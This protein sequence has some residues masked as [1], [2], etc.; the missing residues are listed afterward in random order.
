[1]GSSLSHYKQPAET[2]KRFNL[3]FIHHRLPTGEMQFTHDHRCPHC[4]LIFDPKV[5]MIISFNALKHQL[6]KRLDSIELILEG[7]FLS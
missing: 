6:K 3:R 2:S 1:M 4:Q 7:T 5:H